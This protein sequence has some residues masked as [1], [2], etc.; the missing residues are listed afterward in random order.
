MAN[1]LVTEKCP[2]CDG[3]RVVVKHMTGPTEAVTMVCPLCG[4]IGK[5]TV[6]HKSSHFQPELKK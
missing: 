3:L 2:R 1:L 5:V 6:E 4:G